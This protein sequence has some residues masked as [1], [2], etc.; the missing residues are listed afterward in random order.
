M[1]IKSAHRKLK[2]YMRMK[3]RCHSAQQ[4]PLKYVLDKYVL[5]ICVEIPHQWKI[6]VEMVDLRD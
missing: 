5:N 1:L 3:S 2:Y 4:F 6:Q